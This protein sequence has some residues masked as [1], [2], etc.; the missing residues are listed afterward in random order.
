MI[1]SIALPMPARVAFAPLFARCTPLRLARTARHFVCGSNSSDEDSL[2]RLTCRAFAPPAKRE[3]PKRSWVAQDGSSMPERVAVV[4]GGLAGLAVTWHLLNSTR[5]MA[6]KRGADHTCIHVT[7]FDPAS[8]GSAGATAAAAGLLHP[9]TPRVKKKCWHAK[10]G[11]PAA[12]HL[13]GQAQEHTDRPLLVRSGILR[14]ALDER[15]LKDY[16]VAARRYPHEVTFWDV[17]KVALECPSAPRVPGA[18]LKYGSVVDVARYASA[19][20]AA[21][22]TSGRVTWVREAV[23]DIRP[24]VGVVGDNSFDAVVLANGASI[25][26]LDGID[27]PIMPCRGQNVVFGATSPS[28]LVPPFPIISGKYIVPDL[29]DNG[30]GLIGGAT[31]E[32]RDEGETERDFVMHGASSNISRAHSNLADSLARLVPS[33]PHFWAP[34]TAVAGMR[35]LPPRSK[36]GSVPLA[37]R[38]QGVPDGH[39]LWMLSGLGSRGLLHHAYLGKLVAQAVVAGNEQLIPIDARRVL[40]SVIT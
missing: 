14:L 15:A 37:A 2:P 13:I 21:C 23:S 36:L 20:A 9:F 34:S 28:S 26:A 11:V 4:G 12:E 6:K 35:A 8:P 3:R 17:D 7:V 33:L 1:S 29:F 19:L 10:K 31:F 40:M 38:L 18:F 25:R 32:Y 30:G 5:R 39:S 16:E 22:E 24:L 27:V